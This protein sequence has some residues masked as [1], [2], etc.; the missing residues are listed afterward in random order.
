MTYG[1]FPTEKMI[2]TYELHEYKGVIDA[3]LSGKMVALEEQILENAD[4]FISSGVY[5]VIE[6]LRMMTLRNF[7]KKI[8]VAIN[9]TPALQLHGK[10]NHVNL[11]LLYRPLTKWD[12]DLDL[13]ELE[14]L[15]ANLMG[16]G[17][18]RGYISH[19]RRILVLSKDAF[20]SD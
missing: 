7:V 16:Q 6:K 1:K 11:Q 8:T 13:D 2:E 4:Q 19:E 14:C 10:Q 18:L 3:C 5:T 20:A 17:L 12:P 9:A 15:I